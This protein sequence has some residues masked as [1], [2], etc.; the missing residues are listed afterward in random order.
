MSNWMFGNRFLFSLCTQS[1]STMSH[2][3][4][5]AVVTSPLLDVVAGVTIGRLHGEERFFEVWHQCIYAAYSSVLT[6]EECFQK[7]HFIVSVHRVKTLGWTAYMLV[8]FQWIPRS[9]WRPLKCECNT[10]LSWDD[11]DWTLCRCVTQHANRQHVLHTSGRVALAQRSTCCLTRC[12]DCW[13]LMSLDV[14]SFNCKASSPLHSKGRTATLGNTSL[15]LLDVASGG[16]LTG[17]VGQ[18]TCGADVQHVR[19]S[20]ETERL[21]VGRTLLMLVVFWLGLKEV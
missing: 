14:R 1:S 10:C 18:L 9:C 3:L 12:L 20:A 6:P 16:G 11:R 5:F 15:S 8:W 21:S 13:W 4:L 2:C 17:C 7:Y 19:H